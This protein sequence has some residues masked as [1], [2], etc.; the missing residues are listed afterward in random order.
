MGLKI[1]KNEHEGILWTTM[2]D[3]FGRLSLSCDT[4]IAHLSDDGR[5]S[6]ITVARSGSDG[7]EAVVIG[8][9]EK[10]SEAMKLILEDKKNPD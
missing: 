4:H 9:V 1:E 8:K 3:D 2:R 7:R 10:M 5:K 6:Y